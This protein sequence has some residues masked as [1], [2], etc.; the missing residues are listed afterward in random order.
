MGHK[1]GIDLLNIKNANEQLQG[2][3]NILENNQN[4]NNKIN[5]YNDFMNFVNN[6]QNQY[7]NIN[8]NLNPFQAQNDDFFNDSGEE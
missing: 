4:Q 6:N 2:N 5:K 3:I 8:T 1:N 7:N